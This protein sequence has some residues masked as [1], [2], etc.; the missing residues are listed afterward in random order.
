M[1]LAFDWEFLILFQVFLNCIF[2]Y[3]ENAYVYA[4]VLWLYNTLEVCTYSVSSRFIFKKVRA[5]C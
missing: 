5:L 4:F 2:A 1:L 3:T